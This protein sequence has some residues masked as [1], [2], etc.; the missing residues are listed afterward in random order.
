MRVTWEK[1]KEKERKTPHRC[2][3]TDDQD[4]HIQMFYIGSICQ[5]LQ[6]KHK[7]HKEMLELWARCEDPVGHIEPFSHNVPISLL[8]S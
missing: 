5:V 1:R 2:G 8:V 3:S 4:T 7:L 6:E